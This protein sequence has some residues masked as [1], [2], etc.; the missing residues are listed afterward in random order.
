[1]TIEIDDLD[2]R[3][4]D[5]LKRDGRAT[6]KAIAQALGIAESTVATRLRQLRDDKVMLVALRRD[7]HSKGFDLQCFVDVYV[8]GRAVETVARDIAKI[9]ATTSVSLMLGS[10]EIF[11][12]FNARDRKDLLRVMID[13]LATVK[14]IARTEIFTSLQIRKYQ[15]GYANL[16]ST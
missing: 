8:K 2:R 4:I 15:T 9:E 11:V 10:P 16:A 1:M 13:E 7:L 5:E 3:L 14:G 12:V 6:N